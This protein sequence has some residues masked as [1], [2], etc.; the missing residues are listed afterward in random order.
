[1]LVAVVLLPGCSG[2]I[3]VKRG[4][5]EDVQ[6]QLT[7]SVLSTGRLSETSRNLLQRGGLLEAY[8]RD[9]EAALE[10]AHEWL[11]QVQRA[12]LTNATMASLV[13]LSEACFLHALKSGDRRY[14]MQSAVYAWA[15]LFA[16]PKPLDPLDPQVRL[17]ANLYNRGL[18]LT[19]FAEGSGEGIEPRATTYELPFGTV[20]DVSLDPEELRWGDRRFTRF[21]PVADL[22]IRGLRNRYREAGIGAP[23]AATTRRDEDGSEEGGS[24]EDGSAED[25]AETE[26]RR[27]RVRIPVSLVLVIDDVMAG[28]RVGRLESHVRIVPFSEEP[29][30]EIAGKLHPVELEPS[31]ALALTLDEVRPW[32]GEIGAFFSGDARRERDGLAFL[33]PHRRGRIPVILVHGTASS[34]A[35]WA[36]LV[37][38]L[39]AD[40]ELRGRYEFWLFTYNTGAPVLYSA[41]L[42]RKAIDQTVTRLDPG[43]EDAALRRAVV[44]GHSQG[45]LLTKLMAVQSGDA[46]WE[47]ISETPFD[48][49]E[50]KPETRELVGSAVFV[51][52]SPYVARVVFIATP[53]RGSYLL[54]YGVTNLLRSL[55]RAPSSVVKATSDLVTQNPESAAV[56]RIDDVEGALGQMDPSSPFLGLLLEMPVE[57]PVRAHSII[58]MKKLVAKDEGTDGVV[59][60]DSAHLDEV[61]SEVVVQ[62]GHSC[63]DQ[64]SVA[65]EVRRILLMN[66]LDSPRSTF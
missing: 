23:L 40:P 42:L 64:P 27:D 38:D 49:L 58:A 9:P 37:N 66:L 61:E 44:I 60:Y 33:S 7:A 35:T 41:S 65:G 1:M 57:A 15:F 63:L 10:T 53:H 20:L 24:S 25:G 13:A 17:A 19:L 47:R 3:G 16:N 55:V 4:S 26:T 56:R 51:E 31:A 39:E 28:L 30:I 11:V 48:D 12:R 59:R 43:G 22:E 54:S 18:T 21:T 45:G 5:A 14:F 2:P 6:R 50:M 46:F 34:T 8:E 62:S 52:P 32:Q 29:T 36:N